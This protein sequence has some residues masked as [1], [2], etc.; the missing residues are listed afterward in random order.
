MPCS[1]K[2]S[3]R[4]L[5]KLSQLMGAAPA[6]LT[7]FDENT[8]I[9]SKKQQRF[10]I[11]VNIIAAAITAVSIIWSINNHYGFK[12]NHSK[13]VLPYL[14]VCRFIFAVCNCAVIM[15]GS[16]WQRNNYAYLWQR[17]EDTDRKLSA[18]FGITKA[19]FVRMDCRL[20]GFLRRL[21]A[22]LVV[23][24]VLT[25]FVSLQMDTFLEITSAW[26]AFAMPNVMV[27]LCLMQYYALLRIVCDRFECICGVLT[28]ADRRF[29]EPQWLLG[30]EENV[31]LVEQVL[32]RLQR[33]QDMYRDVAVLESEVH[34]SFG[35]L[36]VV[37]VLTSFV[38]ITIEMYQLYSIVIDARLASPVQLQCITW[39]LF[40]F[41][42]LYVALQM[43]KTI[44]D[45]VRTSR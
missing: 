22:P 21:Y 6:I 38:L 19:N 41:G 26:T 4:Q 25:V 14:N 20:I 29:R 45:A 2:S 24:V 23:L 15:V 42:T 39:M 3:I 16:L 1:K 44:G 36:M 33:A 28:E 7:V 31:Q 37:T 8:Q 9:K 30:G 18:A 40:H 34:G 11:T 17:I 43:C 32:Q 13:I 5:I 35:V 10:E 12:N 27:Y